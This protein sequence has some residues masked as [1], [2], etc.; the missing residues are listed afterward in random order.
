MIDRQKEGQIEIQK[1]RNTDRQKKR[2][3]ER[4]G[5]LKMKTKDGVIDWK[6][7]R[8]REEIAF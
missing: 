4:K 7:N 2:N 8:Q 1:Y 3:E 6:T 5:E